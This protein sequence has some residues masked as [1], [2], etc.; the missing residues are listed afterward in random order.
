MKDVLKMNKGRQLQVAQVCR[1]L[2]GIEKEIADI[3]A[4]EEKL[5]EVM[6]ARN[7]KPYARACATLY[8]AKGLC[9]SGAGVFEIAGRRRAEREQAQS[10]LIRPFRV[11]ARRFHAARRWF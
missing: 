8:D 5:C 2:K 1:E 10:E 4:K 11:A 9:G 7:A 6:R 3:L